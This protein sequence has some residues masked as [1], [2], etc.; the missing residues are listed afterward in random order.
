VHDLTRQSFPLNRARCDELGLSP[1]MYLA[2]PLAGLHLRL[3]LVFSR[4]CNE[5]LNLNEHLGCAYPCSVLF[6]LSNPVS[7]LPVTPS[8]GNH[9]FS[10]PTRR[11]PRDTARNVENSP[12]PPPRGVFHVTRTSPSHLALPSLRTVQ[13]HIAKRSHGTR[14]SH[15]TW[16]SHALGPPQGRCETSALDTLPT[17]QVYFS[18]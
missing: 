11:F 4:L 10:A 14:R 18:T 12:F 6:R 15:M 16:R 17:N 8:R 9:S 7:R 3:D 2:V 5:L 1:H 13:S